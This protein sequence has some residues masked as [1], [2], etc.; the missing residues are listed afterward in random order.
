MILK[1]VARNHPEYIR[2]N[3]TQTDKWLGWLNL[4][5]KVLTECDKKVLV[6][7]DEIDELGLSRER[8][9]EYVYELLRLL[10]GIENTRNLIIMATTNRLD[11]LDTALLR[12]GRFGPIIP[13]NKPDKE[14]RKEIIEY[15]SNRYNY[16]LDPAK[17]VTSVK[18]E[19]SGAD[20]RVAIEDCLIQNNRISTEEVIENLNHLVNM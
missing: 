3:L 4:F 16:K 5:A 18:G 13:V 12:P 14:Q 1:Q 11:D 10:D 15:Y 9:G 8:N 2:C 19:Y 20:I 6:L 17:I 7:I